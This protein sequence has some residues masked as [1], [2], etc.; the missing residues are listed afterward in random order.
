MKITDPEVIRNGEKDLIDA[1]KEDLDIDV[2]REILEKKLAT[3]ALTS[4]GG[5]IVVHNNKIAFR[6]DFELN[7]SGS[8]MFDRSGN[9][10]SETGMPEQA[11]TDEEPDKDIEEFPEEHETEDL[12][13]DVPSQE[14]TADDMDSLIDQSLDEIEDEDMEQQLGIDDEESQ[15][16][17]EIE[18]DL[19]DDSD[20]LLDDRLE[21]DLPEEDVDD[22][23][24]QEPE[25][26][27]LSDQET[28]ML[29]PLEDE[30]IDTSAEEDIIQDDLVDS[31]IDDIL[32]ESEEFWD[33]NSDS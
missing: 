14:N 20:D 1:V 29:E 16:L 31:E 26:P 21:I 11:D 27:E 12:P 7:L 32:K 2:I 6:L 15:S 24:L 25:E 19:K 18:A 5:E 4:K 9:Y 23:S 33:Q 17:E 22:L 8:L 3:Q 28:D 30:E 10:I 13:D